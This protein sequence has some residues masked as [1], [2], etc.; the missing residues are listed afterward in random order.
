MED[1]VVVSW[2]L[3]AVPYFLIY[4][5]GLWFALRYRKPRL[6]GSYLAAVGFTVLLA[7]WACTMWATWLRYGVGLDESESVLEA[8]F[9]VAA[10]GLIAS[11]LDLVGLAIL[12]IALFTGRGSEA[13]AEERVTPDSA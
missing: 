6:R 13:V 8:A 2:L 5:G 4:A 1:D 9:G 3:G 10:W 11:V 7:Q 12:S